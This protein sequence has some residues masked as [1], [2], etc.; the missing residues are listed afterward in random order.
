[1]ADWGCISCELLSEEQDA[2]Q[3]EKGSGEGE[4]ERLIREKGERSRA[5]VLGSK[6]HK[7][8][9]TSCALGVSRVSSVV[10]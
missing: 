6:F 4:R 1:M 8:R 2:G 10:L 3:R 5:Q 7:A 9:L